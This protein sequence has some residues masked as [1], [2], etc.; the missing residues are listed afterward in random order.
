MEQTGHDRAAFVLAEG[1]QA[2]AAR[3]KRLECDNG[4]LL[5]ATV[6]TRF[7]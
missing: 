1:L 2:A 3:A 4:K 7:S 5:P 6:L